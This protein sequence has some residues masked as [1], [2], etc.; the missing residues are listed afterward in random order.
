M[1]TF[2]FTATGNSLYIAKRIGGE[3]YSLPQMMKEGKNEF[4]DEKGLHRSC[5]LNLFID[6][7]LKSSLM[8]GIGSLLSMTI[9]T[10]VRYVRRSGL[11][12]NIT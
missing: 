4:E 5:P 12:I 7:S 3:L 8:K 10:F 11:R 9:V 6:F 2:Y 1:K